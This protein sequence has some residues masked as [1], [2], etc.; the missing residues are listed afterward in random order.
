M[1]KKQTKKTTELKIRNK[2]HSLLENRKKNMLKEYNRRRRKKK[3][4]KPN[5]VW[6]CFVLV[7]E[8]EKTRKKI[9]I[10]FIHPPEKNLLPFFSNYLISLLSFSV[11]VQV[12]F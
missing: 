3:K 10:F 6:V 5:V 12:F 2:N 11:V 8:G 7:G 4:E 9:R 1:K